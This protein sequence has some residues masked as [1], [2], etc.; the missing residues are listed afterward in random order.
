MYSTRHEPTSVMVQFEPSRF[1]SPRSAVPVDEASAGIGWFLGRMSR[2]RYGLRTA[3]QGVTHATFPSAGI[4]SRDKNGKMMIFNTACVPTER[5]PA[6]PLGG[7][8]EPTFEGWGGASRMRGGR[9]KDLF[10]PSEYLD[11]VFLPRMRRECDSVS[12]AWIREGSGAGQG[13]YSDGGLNPTRYL[14]GR[15]IGRWR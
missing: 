10:L 13:P 3:P 11:G 6:H 5:R 15:T 12:C 2:Y 9:I 7:T 8:E 14:T 1:S 4:L